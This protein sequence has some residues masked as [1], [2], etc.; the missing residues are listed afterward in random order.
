MESSERR[1]IPEPAI[2]PAYPNLP[3]DLARQF[4]ALPPMPQR[5]RGRGR[6]NR[7]RARATIVSASVSLNQ[8][9]VSIWFKVEIFS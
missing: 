5:S 8:V 9:E 3:P 4:A 6:G 2:V 7:G 1:R